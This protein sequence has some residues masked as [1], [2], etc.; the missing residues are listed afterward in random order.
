MDARPPGTGIFAPPDFP[1][2]STMICTG[3]VH[4]QIIPLPAA[5]RLGG[6]SRLEINGSHVDASNSHSLGMNGT[7]DRR[8]ERNALKLAASEA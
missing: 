7:D 3:T 5:G 1:L 4:P 8:S 6:V 2:L